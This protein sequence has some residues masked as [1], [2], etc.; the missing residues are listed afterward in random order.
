MLIFELS[1]FHSFKNW[2][3]RGVLFGYKFNQNDSEK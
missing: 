2:H 3:E 1:M